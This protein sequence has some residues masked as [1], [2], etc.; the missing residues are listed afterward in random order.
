MVDKAED[1]FIDHID[2]DNLHTLRRLSAVNTK[3]TE[4]HR[5]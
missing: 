5:Q 4:H 2:V 1:V 3:Y